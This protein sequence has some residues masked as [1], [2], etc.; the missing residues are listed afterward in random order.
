M[1]PRSQHEQI[2][3]W[4]RQHAQRY[5]RAVA[6]ACLPSSHRRGRKPPPMRYCPG[7]RASARCGARR[8]YKLAEVV[9]RRRACLQRRQTLN[10]FS[11]LLPLHHGTHIRARL[12]NE[13]RFRATAPP[14]CRAAVKADGRHNSRSRLL[15]ERLIALLPTQSEAAQDAAPPVNNKET[16][17]R[18]PAERP[19]ASEASVRAGCRK[20]RGSLR[21][22]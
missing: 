19:P 13:S 2:S 6:S 16:R 9:G 14:P 12:L 10:S 1:L 22:D 18:G 17:I 21:H 8:R 7:M 11:Y 20:R 5:R 3:T 4:T 15:K